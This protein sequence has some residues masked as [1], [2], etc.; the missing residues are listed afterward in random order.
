[1]PLDDIMSTASA[2]VTGYFI[3]AESFCL[4]IAVPESDWL[5]IKPSV[6]NHRSGRLAMFTQSSLENNCVPCFAWIYYPTLNPGRC[7]IHSRG[8]GG[9]S[10]DGRRV[11]TFR[12]E[13]N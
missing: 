1:M 8:G 4:K 5:A 2:N 13:R 9:C 10:V 7:D 12:A 6:G 3:H 11:L